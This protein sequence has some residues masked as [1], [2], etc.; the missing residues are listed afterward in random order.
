MQAEYKGKK[1]RLRKPFYTP[2]GPKKSAVHVKSKSGNVI[3]VPFGDPNMRIRKSNPKH[4]RSFRKRH[5]C[6][7][8]KDPT[9]PGFWSCRA[10]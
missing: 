1:V 8:K 10:W 3:K 5:K 7:E 4:R 2:E 9:T 6:S